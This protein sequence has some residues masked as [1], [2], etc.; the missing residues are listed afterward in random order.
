MITAIVATA[1]KESRFV[2]GKVCVIS[3][4]CALPNSNRISHL[5]SAPLLQ[6]TDVALYCNVRRYNLSM[7]HN[8]KSMIRQY[9]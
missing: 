9:P 7:F 8:K 2:A 1:F 6:V 3:F 5:Y 4:I